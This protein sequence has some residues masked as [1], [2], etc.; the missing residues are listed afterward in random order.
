MILGPMA[1]A[2]FRNAMSI[3]EGHLAVFVERPLSATVLA[4]CVLVL[5]VP[6]LLRRRHREPA[7]A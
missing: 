7:A 4:L 6:P 1:E 5:A 2:Q 3:G